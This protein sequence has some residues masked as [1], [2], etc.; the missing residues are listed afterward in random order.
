MGKFTQF[1][2]YRRRRPEEQ[3]EDWAWLQLICRVSNV[4]S[5]KPN[6]RV[7]L[8]LNLGFI[9]TKPS[10][11]KHPQQNIS[12]AVQVLCKQVTSLVLSQKQEGAASRCQSRSQRMSSPVSDDHFPQKPPTPAIYFVCAIN[13]RLLICDAARGSVWLRPHVPTGTERISK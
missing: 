7:Q 8:H 10:S 13:S 5:R 3:P 12:C 1:H 2:I 6:A 11:Y 9:S 4:F